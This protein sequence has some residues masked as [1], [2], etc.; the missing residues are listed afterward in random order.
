MLLN[1]KRIFIIEDNLQNRIIFQVMLT[2]HGARALFEPWG[3]RA[4]LQLKLLG[5]IDLI[6]MDLMLAGGISGYDIFD[7]IRA[8]PELAHIPILAVSAADPA[9][10]I[11]KAREKGFVGFIAK[12]IDDELFPKQ[13][14]DVIGGE[15]VWHAGERAIH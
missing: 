7:Q 10:A 3:N 8:V 12:P 11:A 15:R 13:I 6:I 5:H 4:I 2:K 9:S 1:N 14:A